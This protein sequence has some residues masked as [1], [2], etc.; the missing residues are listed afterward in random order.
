G[1][2]V[3][4]DG[5]LV[6]EDFPISNILTDEEEPAIA[7][8]DSGYLV[9]WV[10]YR[11][12]YPRGAD[13]YG[14]R[15]SPTGE[16]LGDAFRVC[17]AGALGHENS[18]A[19]DWNGSEALV[20]WEDGRNEADRDY[21]IYGRRV[22]STGTP[23]EADFRVSGKNALERE[24]NPAVAWNGTEH[25]VVWEDARD[26]L[27]RRLDIRG[28][29][30]SA[31]GSPEGRDFRISGKTATADDMYP[32][33][34]SDGTGYLVVWEDWRMLPDRQ[35]DIYGRLVSA[36]GKPV[37]ANFRVC[38]PQATGW[39]WAPAIT[40]DGTVPVYLVAWQDERNWVDRGS[41]IFGRRV[42]GDGSRVGGDF[43]ISGPAA[44]TYEYSPEAAWSGSGHLVVWQDTREVATRDRDIWGRRVDM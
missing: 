36:V 16:L 22:S 15:L 25:L 40:W 10:D 9:V 33:V 17:G 14:Q 43:R 18:P 6:G 3:A 41:D 44:T 35:S 32:V 24:T 5:A 12:A 28:R 4:A 30:V 20:V 27:D 13:I 8:T 29:R 26:D 21:D 38:G 11:K 37:G 39:D 42:A 2:R 23:L 34:A 1:R 19:I 31:A 7:A